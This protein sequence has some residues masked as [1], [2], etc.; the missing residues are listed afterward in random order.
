[1]ARARARAGSSSRA[2]KGTRTVCVQQVVRRVP[3][4]GRPGWLRRHAKALGRR[5]HAGACIAGCAGRAYGV[6][7]EG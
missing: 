4:R 5:T 1:M 6:R 3:V 2:A 7:P